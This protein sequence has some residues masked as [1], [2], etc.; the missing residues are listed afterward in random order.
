[1]AERLNPETGEW[2]SYS[3]MAEEPVDYQRQMLGEIGTGEAILIGAGREFSKLGSG[4]ADLW[5]RLTGDEEG[6]TERE[7]EQAQEDRLYAPLAEDQPIA[8]AAGTALPYVSTGLA[9]IARAAPK[10]V[11]KQGLSAL[12]KSLGLGTAEGAAIGGLHYDDT[13]LEGAGYGLGGTVV[14]KGV[15]K[16]LGGTKV[17]LSE[18]E[19]PIVE[20]AKRNKL[21]VPP[22]MKTGNIR[23]QQLDQGMRTG[24]TSNIIEEKVRDSGRKMNQIIS[25]K[26]GDKAESLSPTFFER[27][28]GR[29]GNK[30]DD[31][32]KGTDGIV[33]DSS[34]Y[35][36]M[37]ISEEFKR[38]AGLDKT[39]KVLKDVENSLIGIIENGGKLSGDQYEKITKL[40]GKQKTRQF[41]GVAGDRDLGFA[42]GKMKG[43][44]DDAIESGMDKG[45]SSQWAKARKEY[46]L[47]SNAEKATNVSGFVDPS[48]MTK[49]FK[50]D[51]DINMLAKYMDLRKGQ[52]GA[53]LSTSH[54]LGKIF[55]VTQ[56]P[57]AVGML[58]GERAAGKIPMLKGGLA[59]LYLSGYPHATGIAP[60]FG[61]RTPEVIE[62][63]VRRGTYGKGAPEDEAG[64]F[65]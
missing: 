2:E 10:I 51:P 28:Y 46:A 55:N 57:T 14:G 62:S 24:A 27:N 30:M 44:F 25:G 17:K 64:L 1:M 18:A 52:R 13:L 19:E 36:A 53:S 50:S 39:P 3:G 59:N 4:A 34:V 9:G 21:F 49:K 60:V 7:I 23:L 41:S 20:F 56:H 37:D 6:M 29:I 11:G 5:D 38:I 65:D 16:L 35:K 8:T 32:A 63:M 22:G 43:L 42:L 48:K 26:I 15:G 45:K 61:K 31:L 33:D 12:M 47:L 58:L 54:T 40:I